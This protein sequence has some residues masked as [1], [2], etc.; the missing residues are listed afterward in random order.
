MCANLF[1][2]GLHSELF[3]HST[4][5]KQCTG[6]HGYPGNVY[7]VVWKVGVTHTYANENKEQPGRFAGRI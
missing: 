5:E 7:L 3:R 1:K 6:P 2:S 4:A